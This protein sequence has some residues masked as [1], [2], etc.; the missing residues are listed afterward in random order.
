MTETYHAWAIPRYGC[1]EV[2]EPVTPPRQTPTGRQLQ[3]EIKASAVTRADCM[4]RA[5]VPRFARAFLGLSRPRNNLVGTGLSGVITAIGPGVK[6]FAVGDA[7]FGES[8][9]SFGA[10]ASHICLEEDALLLQKP[11]SLPHAQASTLCDGPLTSLHFLTQVAQLHPGQRLLVLG[12]SGSLGSAA[13]Q[14]ARH[15]GAEVTAT[16]STRNAAQVS[17]LGAQQ[18]IDYTRLDIA[19]TAETFDVI[20]D[21]LGAS[22]FGRLKHNLAAGGRY[23]CPVLD[24]KLLCA[25]LATWLWGGRRAQF[26]AA[27]LQPVHQLRDLLTQL[28]V[29]TRSG[30]LTPLMDRH[31][32]LD[33][34][35]A[36][37][38]YV[39]TGRKVGNVVVMGSRPGSTTQSQPL[40]A[41]PPPAIPGAK[42]RD[43][44]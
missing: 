8:G 24:A 27:G 6:R 21:T 39:D 12:G 43:Q 18:V 44:G 25:A 1:P 16:C 20:Y 17:A 38:R 33:E 35:I 11:D 9:L 22:S 41:P 7:V 42:D 31:Y 13:I 36:A 40:P 5:G 34:L 14:I 3:I 30:A 29:L 10:N 37:H 15:L 19:D 4:M 23:L 32:G 2:L 26:S 28:L